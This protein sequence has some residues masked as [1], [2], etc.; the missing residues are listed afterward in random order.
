MSTAN[1]IADQDLHWM[2]RALELA[3]RGIGV[4]SPN[5]AVGCVILDR[6]GQV[7]GEGWHEYDLLDHAEVVAL[8]EAAH[9]RRRPRPRRHRLRHP[10]A[11][12]HHRPHAA[13]HRRAHQ[14]RPR[15]ASSPPPSIPIP[16][17]PATASKHCVPQAFKS[18]SASCEAEARRL[19]EG[20]ARW[21]QHHRPFVLM[22]VAMTLDARIAPPPAQHNAPRA[23]LDHQRSRAR[24][25]AAP[26]L[27]RRRHH[28]R[29]RHRSRRR[30]LDD[31]PQRPAPPPSA[32][33]HRPRLRTAH[34]AR[35][36][37]RHHSAKR[38]R[39]LHR[40]PRRSPHPRTRKPRRP[41]RSPARGYQAASRSKKSSTSSAK[42]ASSPCSL[43]PARASTP[44]SSPPA[45]ST[46][47][48]SSSRRRSWGPTPS[49]P[50]AECPASCT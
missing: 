16:P 9:A 29:R 37:T 38:R 48:I 3:R 17:S 46:A 50:S 45:S 11:L 27:G 20:F 2:H 32:P 6:A 26:A 1:T 25:R 24:R 8:R 4:T 36:Q 33:A 12:Q 40:L 30:S 10:R 28:G 18:P 39:H 13:L 44:H 31:R 14:V 34:A 19:N 15:A 41:R 43:K 35:L 49:P 47:S 22:K 42:K 5:P 21:I 23:L 7:V